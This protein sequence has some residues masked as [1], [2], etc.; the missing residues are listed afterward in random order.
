MLEMTNLTID[1][2]NWRRVILGAIIVASKVLIVLFSILVSTISL[3][4][5][6]IDIRFGKTTQYGH[7]T[8]YKYLTTTYPTLFRT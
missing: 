8:S 2:S 5:V 1:A 7:K 4:R 3:F 6:L